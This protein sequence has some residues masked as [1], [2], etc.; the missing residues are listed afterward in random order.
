MTAQNL[1]PARPRPAFAWLVGG[2]LIAGLAYGLTSLSRL[3]G[4][5]LT[6]RSVVVGAA[7]AHIEKA[8]SLP[9]KAWLE[10]LDA[11]WRYR[12]LGQ[13]GTQVREGCPGW[14][15]YVDG[16]R[17]PVPNAA[18]VM[19]H[20]IKLM[21][22]L[23]DDVAAAGAKL[24]VVTVPDK[25]RVQKDALCGLTRTPTMQVQVARWNAALR[26]E[27]VAHVDLMAGLDPVA[28]AFYRTDVHLNQH[29]ARAAA[30]AIASA[31]LP[32]LGGRGGQRY[33]TITEPVAQPRTGDLLVLSGLD[34]SPAGWRPA[35]D[36]EARET[37][38]PQSAGD[39][40][41]DGPVLDVLLAG[42]SNSRRSN[43]AEQL[44]KNLGRPIQ[45]VSRDGG[46]FADALV[47]AMGDQARWP[48]TIRLVIWEMSEMSLSQPLSSD[49]K[50][51]LRI[52]SEDLS[53]DRH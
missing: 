27:G 33:I 2:L 31:A 5:E 29:G 38:R 28:S 12:F 22:K 46:K 20:R 6:L 42:S 37:L 14:L 52:A 48:K 25:S 51:M 1:P 30:Q 34:R 41:D 39:L 45:N 32:L 17:A 35:P 18:D 7:G 9:G 47:D 10:P 49:E 16:L 11:A 19:E 36:S 15:F 13:L 8:L 4:P 43:L 40:L 44:G 24:L 3:W 21:R 50:T 23:R 53:S 26:V